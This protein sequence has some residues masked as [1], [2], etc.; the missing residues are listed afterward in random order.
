MAGGGRRSRPGNW[1]LES[2]SGMEA[3]LRIANEKRAYCLVDRATWLAH[4]REIDALAI[5]V[6]GD[7]QLFNPY[8]VIVVSPAKFSWL[9]A[10]LAAPLRRIHP[11]ARRPGHH[12]RFRQGHVRRRPLFPRC[13]ALRRRALPE[14]PLD[15]I[16]E[17][18][19]PGRWRCCCRPA[20]R[21]CRSSPCRWPYRGRRRCWPP[22]RPS[23]PPCSWP[24]RSFAASASWS[25]WSIPPW[26]C[27]PCSSACWST[28]WSA[29]AARWGRWGCCSLPGPW[30]W[31]RRCWLFRSSPPW[32]WRR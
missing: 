17:G 21:S 5:L 10:K 29:A 4:Q 30:S 13:R 31:P 8:S 24:S 25:G 15:Y 28:A 19:Q 12:P 16:L 6:E 9:N 26:R 32:R 11:F 23:P 20:A 14:K 3:T 2:G 18:L 1:Y 22:W 27:R 7:A